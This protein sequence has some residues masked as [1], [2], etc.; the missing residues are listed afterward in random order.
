MPDLWKDGYLSLPFWATGKDY[1]IVPGRHIGADQA[2]DPAGEP[3]DVPALIEADV[4]HTIQTTAIGCVVVTD[5]QRPTRRYLS[6]CHGYYGDPAAQ[7]T[8]LKPG[9]RAVRLARAWE[10]PGTAWG[11]V[12]CHVVA[13]DHPAGAY[14]RV[15]D[16]YYDPLD[17]INQYR[18]STAGGAPR[19]LLLEDSMAIII[20]RQSDGIIGLIDKQMWAHMPDLDTA[21]I[22]AGVYSISDEIHEL[23]DAGF[24]R[25][26]RSV[27]IPDS[28]RVPGVF[29]SVERD[30]QQQLRDLEAKLGK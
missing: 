8:H 24:D 4:H 13:H 11:G 19:P 16:T 27:G 10:N 30:L 7:G 5:T 18:S 17:D 28:V 1:T 15:G 20:R 23:D 12:H 22:N 29:W 6:Y 14:M 21:R 9:D 2:P 25:V 26:T 3:W